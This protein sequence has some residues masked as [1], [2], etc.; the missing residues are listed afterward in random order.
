MAGDSR[1][2]DCGREGRYRDTVT[3]PLTD[4]PVAGYPLVLRV[5]VPRYRCT[6]V[7]CG[8]TVFNQGLGKLAAPRSSTTRRCARYVLCRLMIDRTT[9]SAIAAELGVTSHSVATIAARHRG[10]GRRGRAGSAG[11]SA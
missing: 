6:T 11:G 9:I 5:A 10:L 8:R 4:V 2:P 1:C 3:R 7:E